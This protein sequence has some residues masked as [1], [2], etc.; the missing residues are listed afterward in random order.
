M[1]KRQLNSSVR[2]KWTR[3]T[4]SPVHSHPRVAPR[5]PG[6]PFSL[7]V[8]C[9][10]LSFVLLMSLDVCLPLL[11]AIPSVLRHWDSNSVEV[12]FLLPD[13]SSFCEKGFERRNR[14]GGYFGWWR[15]NGIK[16]VW[17]EGVRK[18]NLLSSCIY[19]WNRKFGIGDVYGIGESV[20]SPI[21]SAATWTSTSYP[22]TTEYRYGAV[23][24]ELVMITEQYNLRICRKSVFVMLW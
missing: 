17:I 18:C 14:I 3:S 23:C 20:L 7:K 5:A 1:K 9:Y 12:Q 22:K 11:A 2:E 21:V 16:C 15:G 8:T 19:W 6:K 4:E 13:S 10:I 24:L